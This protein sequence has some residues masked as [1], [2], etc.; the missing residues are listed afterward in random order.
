MTRKNQCLTPQAQPWAAVEVD[1]ACSEAGSLQQCTVFPSLRA[2]HSSV[3]P[4][5]RFE[6]VQVVDGPRNSRPL[7]KKHRGTAIWTAAARQHGG[8]VGKAKV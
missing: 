6:S 1:I 7:L 3:E 8:F 2:I 4:V 5:N